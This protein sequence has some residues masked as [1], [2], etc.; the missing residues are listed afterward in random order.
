MFRLSLCEYEPGASVFL[1][2]FSEKYLWRLL[3]RADRAKNCRTYKK[4]RR[5]PPKL[6]VLLLCSLMRR[7]ERSG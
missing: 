5:I 3:L 6:F 7:V 2:E 4:P 1:C